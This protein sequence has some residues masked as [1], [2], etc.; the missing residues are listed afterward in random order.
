MFNC[1]SG[2]THYHYR[3]A[4][5][6]GTMQ[7]ESTIVRQGGQSDGTTTLSYKMV[8]NANAKQICP[9]D[10]MEW[11]HYIAAAQ[12]GS[13][14]T[15]T[16]ELVHDSVTALKD[17]EIW[18]EA[19]Y[20]GTSGVPLGTIGSEG[21]DVLATGASQTSSS[22]TWTTTGLTNPNKQ[23]LVFTFTPQEEGYIHYTV[24]LGKAS[25][26]VYVDMKPTVA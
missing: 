10:S 21:I 24:R 25:Y 18:L 7:D 26:T 20:L 17:N 2:D 19:M 23:K 13:S 4:T 15:L 6:F 12:V 8:S 14:R 11:V 1:D 16:I 3:R 5:Q 22:T 9:L